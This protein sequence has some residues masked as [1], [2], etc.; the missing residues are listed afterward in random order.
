MLLGE[1]DFLKSADFSTELTGFS[2]DELDKLFDG[3]NPKEARDDGFDVD[4]AAS[5]PPFVLPQDLW[6]LGNH[7]LLCGDSTNLV[8]IARLTGGKRMN[9]VLTDPPYNVNYEANG[10][11][12]QNDNMSDE[13]FY[14]FL[15]AAFMQ[16]ESVM[17]DDASIYVFYADSKGLVFRRAFDAAGFKLSS[18]CVWVKDNFTFGHSDYKWGHEVCL[19]GWKKSGIHK[20]HGDM[21]QS[22]IWSCPKP[23]KNDGH[24]T[25]K[26]IPLL[27]IPLANSTQ[28]NA[29]VFDPFAGSFST[30]ICCEQLGRVCYGMELDPVYASVC[31]KR[32]VDALGSPDAVIVERAGKT[33]TYAEA[34]HHA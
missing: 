12:I 11:K 27:A 23:K 33:L 32:M 10:K 29:L 9:L 7:R 6:H 8:D 31:V 18:N 34:V 30:G 28:T 13:D 19:Y 5:E 3:Q 2:V 22:T 21:K 16:A 20:W 1:L 24:P 14:K 17:A 25:M 26:P 15:L 4:K